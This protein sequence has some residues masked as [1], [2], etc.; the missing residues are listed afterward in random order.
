MLAA[1]EWHIFWQRI[2][3]P[4]HAFARALWT[5]IYIAVAAQ[6]LGVVLGLVSA[7]MRLAKVWPVRLVSYVYV[8]LFRGTPIIVQ[9]FFVYFGANLFLGFDLFPRSVDFGL[10]QMNGAALAGIVALGVNEGSYMSEI[11]RAGIDAVDKGQMEAAKSVG[12]T[13]RLAMRRIVLPQAAR[14]IVPP[15][16]NEFNNMLKTTSLLAFI[17]VYELFED[18]D[19]HYST[20]FKPSEYFL[21]VA[22][23]Y[24][25]LTTVWSVIQAHIERKLAVSDRADARSFWERVLEAWAPVAAWRTGGSR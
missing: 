8:L 10:F 13:S 15:L 5:T 20:T 23:W 12:M 24:L 9:I 4:D 25:V 16:G 21:A 11:I 2:L 22:F 19:I 17:G 6:L 3:H 1:F 14:V 18:A 7:L